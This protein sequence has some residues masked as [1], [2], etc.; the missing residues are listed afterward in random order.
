MSRQILLVT[1]SGAPPGGGGEIPLELPT[2]GY[3]IPPTAPYNVGTHGVHATDDGTGQT[4]HPDVVDF[5]ATPWNGYRFWMASTAFYN[6]EV[7]RE[8]PHIHASN[9]G[10]NWI[11]PPGLTNPIDPWPGAPSD[12]GNYNSDTDLHYDPADGKLVCTWREMGGGAQKIWLSTSS[13]G[14]TWSTPVLIA[15]INDDG[16]GFTASQSL[17]KVSPTEWRLYFAGGSG[18]NQIDGNGRNR[19][20]RVFTASSRIGP[21]TS[22][23]TLK[24]TGATG[25]D[26]P[27][28][29]DVIL[30]GGVYYG[31]MHQNGREYPC[32]SYNGVDFT[33]RN[34]ILIAGTYGDQ[35]Q[36]LYRACMQ[37]DPNGTTVH[38]WYTA[39]DNTDGRWINY[40]RVPLTR[41]TSG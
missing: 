34:E 14:S 15:S 17:I 32:I 20:C 4:I 2:I 39:Q 19:W 25:T 12:Y 10:Y 29:G 30:K 8:N 1:N 28:H 27:Y 21:F 16:G 31:L 5:G 23:Q 18:A 24:Y 22:H 35:T 3:S 36:S 7:Q 38:V 9:D 13:T 40:T 6:A 41:W 26:G 11:V 33:V 37:I